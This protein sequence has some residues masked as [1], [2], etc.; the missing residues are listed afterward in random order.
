LDDLGAFLTDLVKVATLLLKG[1]K[2]IRKYTS[3]TS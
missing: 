3:E 2:A 1:K